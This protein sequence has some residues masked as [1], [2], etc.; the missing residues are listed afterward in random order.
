MSI[1]H[2]IDEAAL[3]L[4]IYAKEIEA[5][6]LN[7][8][9]NITSTGFVDKTAWVSQ[10]SE[11]NSPAKDLL[12]DWE[13]LATGSNRSSY[14]KFAGVNARLIAPLGDTAQLVTVKGVFSSTVEAG[15]VW[16]F[17]APSF[18]VLEL[19]TQSIVYE[20][21]VA[22][23]SNT[24][25]EYRGFLTALNSIP[26]TVKVVWTNLTLSVGNPVKIYYEY[27]LCQEVST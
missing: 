22:V 7:V 16:S 9:G 11:P 26:N 17:L 3:K 12:Y 14:G 2:L 1:N 21:I 24:G 5:T 20:N 13:N 15:L 25:A 8:S 23:D 27:T 10:E 6:S 18:Q 19:E 4:N